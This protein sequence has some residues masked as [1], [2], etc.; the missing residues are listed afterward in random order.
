MI[1]TNEIIVTGANGQ[2]GRELQAIA[3]EHPEFAFSFLSR[4]ALDLSL[5]DFEKGLHP[6]PQ[7][8]YLINCAAYTAVDRAE[9]EAELAQAIN[10]EAPG[11][12]AAR[13]KELGIRMLHVSTDYVYH[14]QQNTPFRESDPVS[15]K[16][17]YAR[18]KLAGELAVLAAQPEALV[19]R[20]SWVYSSFGNNFV[21]TMLRLGR[22]RAQLGVVSD[23]IGSPTYARDLARTLLLLVKQM[24]AGQLETGGTYNYSN[25]GVASWYDF[26]K[27]IFK[28]KN[29]NCR[30][31]P[32]GTADYPTPAERPPF[33]LMD[34]SKI[35]RQLGIDIPHWQD[36]LQECAVLLG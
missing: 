21:K 8:R 7:A 29:I 3:H 34:K 30:L 6:M 32:I 27:A 14:S 13:C 28:A 9:S 20:T 15:P 4:Q 16:G 36:S 18:T 12:L 35:K 24:D 23:Q 33:S 22:E 2:L 10:A 5:P 25:E 19:V 1:P 26:A 11:K 17:V 31:S